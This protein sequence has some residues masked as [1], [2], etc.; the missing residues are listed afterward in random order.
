MSPEGRRIVL[1]NKA[2]GEEEDELGRQ[3]LGIDP[4]GASPS[5]PLTKLCVLGHDDIREL[6]HVNVRCK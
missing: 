5:Q 2:D 6:E 3:L 4:L 1:H